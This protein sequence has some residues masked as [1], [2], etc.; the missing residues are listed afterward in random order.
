MILRQELDAALGVPRFLNSRIVFF[1]DSHAMKR[2]AE[3]W[4]WGPTLAWLAPLPLLLLLTRTQSAP[5][6]VGGRR[7]VQM[8]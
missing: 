8:L 7:V 3:T 4:I 2:A 1:E 5:E 6:G